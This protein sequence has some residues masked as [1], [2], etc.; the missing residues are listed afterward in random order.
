MWID[1]IPISP[2]VP[3]MPFTAKRVLNTSAT[4]VC[5]RVAAAVRTRTEGAQGRRAEEVQEGRRWRGR[6]PADRLAH[7]GAL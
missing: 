4:K 2:A 7:R 3:T 5:A 6:W 1:L